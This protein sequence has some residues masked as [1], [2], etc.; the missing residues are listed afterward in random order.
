MIDEKTE[1]LASLYALDLLEGAEF[2]GFETRMQGE[3]ELRDLVEDFRNAA[4]AFG[5]GAPR[6]MPPPD[7]ERR[8]AAA[9]LAES[10]PPNVIARQS[11]IPWAIAAGL[12][13][14]CAFLAVDRARIESRIAQLEQRDVFAQT[15]IAMLSSK[16]ES[17]PQA[18]AV[19]IWDSQKQEGVLKVVGAPVTAKDRDYQLWIVDPRYKQPVDGGVFGVAEDGTTKISFR[20][21]AKIESVQAF[22][23]SLERKGGVP[24]AEGPMVLVGK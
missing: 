3:P 18:Q 19:V 9:V 20:P 16:L 1:E 23:V 7:L 8:I 11:W 2:A 5:A 13:A 22:A 17:A 14:T 15:Q 24:K 21:K 10:T 6:R 4:A 12:M